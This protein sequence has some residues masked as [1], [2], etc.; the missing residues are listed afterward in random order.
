MQVKMGI[1]NKITVVK[2]LGNSWFNVISDPFNIFWGLSDHKTLAF[3]NQC[4]S[5]SSSGQIFLTCKRTV[6]DSTKCYE[7]VLLLILP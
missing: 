1:K 3:F 7:E 5:P 6:N 4:M 2:A